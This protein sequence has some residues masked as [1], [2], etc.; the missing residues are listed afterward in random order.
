MTSGELREQVTFYEPTATT[1]TLRGQAVAYTVVVATVWARW[2]GL[3]SR[4]ML[5][6]QAMDVVP[7]Y[8][9]TIRYRDDITTKLRV[10]RHTGPLGAHD[11]MCQVV[12]VT[13]S[14]GTREWLDVDVVEVL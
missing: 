3:T 14:E 1:D 7:Q 13:D 2:R 9:L 12:G 8:R 4:E 5:L 6:A 11:R 10:Q